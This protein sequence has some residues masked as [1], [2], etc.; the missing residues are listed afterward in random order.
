MDCLVSTY[1]ALA[2]SGVD[3]RAA[4]GEE[5]H[6]GIVAGITGGSLTIVTCVEDERLEFQVCAQGVQDYF[7]G[8]E[9]EY[10]CFAG[11]YNCLTRVL[12]YTVQMMGYKRVSTIKFWIWLFVFN[13][14][15]TVRQD[16]Q[17]VTFAEV[18]GM[19]ELNDGKPRR[20]RNCKVRMRLVQNCLTS[21]CVC[22]H[23]GFTKFTHYC[24]ACCIYGALTVW[25]GTLGP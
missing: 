16:G 21:S 10:M 15:Y 18:I 1:T 12:M 14:V 7:R 19:T 8:P 24:T 6:S 11:K 4:A 25:H 17:L 5:P 20:V 9:C 22:G 3:G 23:Q 2:G 13:H